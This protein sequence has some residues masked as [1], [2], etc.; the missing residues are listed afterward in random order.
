MKVLVVG[1]GGR[2]H[3]IVRALRRSPRSPEVLCAPGNAGIAADAACF[4]V[5]ADDVDG[6]VR[7]AQEQGAD[8]TVV[9]P[10]APLVAGL[11]DALE[12][13]GLRAFGPHAEGARLEGSKAFAKELMREAGVPTASWV[14]FTSF[15]E[16]EAQMDCASYPGRSESGRA[17]GRQGRRDRR[18][19]A[20]GQAGA[21]R[22]LCRAQVRRGRVARAGRGVPGGRGALP[23][24]PVR[25]RARRADGAGAGFQANRR[26]ATP[27]RTPAGWGA[28][29]RFRGSTPSAPRRSP[30]PCTSR[31]S[32]RCGRGGFA[33]AGSCT[34]G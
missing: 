9:G 23:A 29:R 24:R 33:T 31:S 10:E 25:R 18:L 11:V 1:G 3:A 6:L 19:A 20:R 34:R 28:T 22:V 27:A 4:D 12:A 13:E 7:L 30:A 2:E 8:L 16:A 17:R 32:T 26:R 15:E 5:A 21:A 14:E